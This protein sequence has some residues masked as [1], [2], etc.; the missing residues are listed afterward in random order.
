MTKIFSVIILIFFSLNLSGQDLIH[1]TTKNGLPSN[2]VYDVAQDSNGFMWFATNRGVVKYDGVSFKT[3]T[4]KDGLPNNDTWKLEADFQ[5]RVWC[6]SKSKYQGYIQNDSIFK[7]IVPD[8]VVITPIYISKSKNKIWIFDY[9]RK[10]HLYRNGN[11]LKK[12]DDE[13]YQKI[14]VF[15]RKKY[16]E[17]SKDSMFSYFRMINPELKQ[18]IVF[19]KNELLV[20][21]FNFKILHQIKYDIPQV[22][23]SRT[24]N[25]GGMPNQT[26]FTT[27]EE[28]I[29]FIDHK[30]NTSKYFT[31][32]K[33]L[34]QKKVNSIFCKALLKE[35]QI[36]VPGHLLR[37]D[38]KFKLIEKISFAKNLL[39]HISYKDLK[40]NIWLVDT[41]NGITFLPISQLETNYYLK[42]KKVQK[43][44]RINQSLFTGVLNDGF[45]EYNFNKDHFSKRIDL[46]SENIYRI[47]Y[48]EE[49]Q[50]GY[51]IAHTSYALK[52]E[53][54]E[55]T[56]IHFDYSI[57]EIVDFNNYLYII[58]A[59]EIYKRNNKTNKESFV[60]SKIGLLTSE[61]YDSTLYIGASDGIH[62]LENDSLTKPSN[63][64]ELLNTP[65]L[66]LLNSQDYLL[67]G[68]D[69]RGIYL[70]NK[71]EV[72]HL[73]NTEDLSIQKIIKK[74]NDL[75][76]A[77]QRGVFKIALDT[78]NLASSTI[79]NTFY[80]EDGLLQNNTNDIYIQDNMLYI[81]SDLG[82]A[83]ININNPIYQKKPNLYFKTE[84]D[85]LQFD[86]GTD[87][88][89]N[90]SFSVLDYTNQENFDYSYRLL[91][92]LKQWLS[93]STKTLNFSNLSPNLYT[94]EVK[95]KDQHGNQI[96]KR[97]YIE[98]IPAWWQT[99]W[100]KIGIT[101]LLVILFG[102]ILKLFQV[103][104][105]KKEGERAQQEKRIAGLEL[106]ALRSQMNPHF[107]HNSLNAILYYIQRSEI[108]QSENYLVKFS[109]LIRLF[110]E[111]SRRQSITIK[112]EVDLLNNYLEV[113]QL[114]FEDKLQYQIQ[115]DERLDQEEQF[116]PSMILQPIVENAVNHGLFHKQGKGTVT[117][118]FIYLDDI[119]FK[120]TIK[121]DGIGIKKAKEIFKN[122]SKNYQSRS[123]DVL[124]ERLALLRQSNDW[125]IRYQI[126][127]LSVS[128]VTSG[129]LVTLIFKQSDNL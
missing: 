67:V 118:A 104:I 115:I 12:L 34:G 85:T 15:V 103:S 79:T 40:G 8:S 33:L 48:D 125:D 13:E 20:L 111:Y 9:T 21:D 47:K 126:E 101:F 70:Y 91:P 116:I 56:Q 2:H 69:G 27:L 113:E 95:V 122:S 82:L 39:G 80:E 22:H 128:N 93:T 54:N 71:K 73:E 86:G 46:N 117:I 57:K 41:K 77:S 108:D 87:N 124:K 107:V 16:E 123:S 72:I 63:K 90:I 61:I 64:N 109:K 68:T 25:S 62:I 52:Y 51:L 94:L 5:G 66:T 65:V 49:R 37:F 81:A 30:T 26:Y 102:G 18:Y 50:L 35:I 7:F 106:Q 99:V 112:E 14:D 127:D 92:N 110:F 11:T 84:M 98:V 75:W 4:V 32:Q 23:N 17:E 44:E 55:L 88:N 1:Y 114:R 74:E 78:Q 53:E 89:I 43:I 24:N 83:K 129:T 42:D 121:D 120:V 76:L 36:S 97:Q 96:I 10:I 45:Y 31:F 59:H 58:T 119:I 19:I 105:K 100:A 38:Y 29:L 6:F 3:F 60:L 28:G